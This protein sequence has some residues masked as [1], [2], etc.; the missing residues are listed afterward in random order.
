MSC[1]N[2]RI[3][4]VLEPPL[5]EWVKESATAQGI[6][7]SL[8]LRDIIQQAYELSEDLYWARVGEDR[9]SKR[10]LYSYSCVGLINELF[11]TLSSTCVKRRYPSS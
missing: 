9:L 4:T 2:P 6:S 5:Y 3:N 7:I 11:P 10:N 8:K 1:K